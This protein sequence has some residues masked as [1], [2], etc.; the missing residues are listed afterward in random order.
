LERRR[1]WVRA[2]RPHPG[3]DELPHGTCVSPWPNWNPHVRAPFLLR[4]MH[5]SG[6]VRSCRAPCRHRLW[7]GGWLGRAPRKG[8]NWVDQGERRGLGPRRRARVL[9]RM[10]VRRAPG[11]RSRARTARAAR[12]ALCRA[13]RGRGQP[14]VLPRVAA[15]CLLLANQSTPQ[16]TNRGTGETPVAARVQSGRSRRVRVRRPCRGG[17]QSGRSRTVSCRS[18]SKS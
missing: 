6:R 14:R 17:V 2:T 5:L 8:R 12:A 1:T 15:A 10:S 3:K 7:A 9:P 11:S 4:R 16:R 13:A 18:V